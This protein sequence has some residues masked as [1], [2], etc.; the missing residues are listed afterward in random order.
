MGAILLALVAPTTGAKAETISY[1][2]AV[3]VLARDCGK[4]IKT[5]CKGVNI[6]NNAIAN[7]LAKNQAKVSQVC[8]ASLATVVA[9]IQQRQAA[10]AS[11]AKV[12]FTDAK[13]WCEGVVRK[14]AYTL[15]C[16][17]KVAKHVTAKCNSAITNAG[18]R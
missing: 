5:Y 10:Q 16:L 15:D 17:L 8:T 7:C 9:S 1:A 3:T 13:R 12:C 11:V 18:W 2:D 4:D 6:G 14:E